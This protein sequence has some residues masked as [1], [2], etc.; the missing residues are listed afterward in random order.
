MTAPQD[1][2]T[3]AQPQAAVLRTALCPPAAR[4][5]SAALPGWLSDA[6]GDARRHSGELERNGASEF[7]IG[8]G[9]TAPWVERAARAQRRTPQPPDGDGTPY[10][11]T[12]PPTYPDITLRRGEAARLLGDARRSRGSRMLSRFL[13]QNG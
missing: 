4:A 9:Q 2:E 3:P 6:V 8:S 7:S 10:T 12:T 1:F 5:P 11:G 13:R